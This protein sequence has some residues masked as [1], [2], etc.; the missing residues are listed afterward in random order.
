MPNLGGYRGAYYAPHFN[1]YLSVYLILDPVECTL[2]PSTTALAGALQ[3]SSLRGSLQSVGG[4]FG[5]LQ[6]KAT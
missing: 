4:L 1:Q 5:S 6:R 2:Q 3:S